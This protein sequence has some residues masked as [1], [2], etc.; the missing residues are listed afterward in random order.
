MITP[1]PEEICTIRD[2][3]TRYVP[4]SFIKYSSRD[5][6]PDIG[7][8]DPRYVSKIL[9]DSSQLN[10]NNNNSNNNNSNHNHHNHH[11]NNHNNNN[12]SRFTKNK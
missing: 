6:I 10:N 8:I 7:D 2:Q 3:Y 12:N 11:N 9:A 4:N 1:D 5:G